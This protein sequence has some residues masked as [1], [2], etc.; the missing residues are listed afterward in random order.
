[1]KKNTVSYQNALK[2]IITDLKTISESTR[3]S[4]YD[5]S[6]MDYMGPGTEEVLGFDQDKDKELKTH[7]SIVDILADKYAQEMDSDARYIKEEGEEPT[8]E[9]NL[10]IETGSEPDEIDKILDD[11]E[12][13]ITGDE[14]GASDG[15]YITNESVEDEIVSRLLNEMEEIDN[16]IKQDKEEESPQAGTDA[17]DKDGDALEK[18]LD[19]RQDGVEADFAK[20]NHAK[21][22]E[23]LNHAD[24]EPLDIQE[25][26]NLI[27]EDLEMLDEYSLLEDLLFEDET[28]EHEKSETKEEEKKEDGAEDDGKKDDKSSEELDV[29]KNIEEGR[30]LGPIHIR[31]EDELLKEAYKV[32]REELEKD[33]SNMKPKKEEEEK[34]EVEEKDEPKE[35]KEDKDEDVTDKDVKEKLEKTEPEPVKEEQE[36]PEQNEIE[37]GGTPDKV[38]KTKQDL[39]DELLEMIMNEDIDDIDVASKEAD[40]EKDIKKDKDEKD[41]KDGDEEIE[42][43]ECNEDFNF[44][45]EFDFLNENEDLLEEILNSI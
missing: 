44:D 22:E 2:G 11:L 41:E 12:D 23:A 10:E 24:D 32:F 27:K 18:E 26:I 5:V 4:E 34:E 16:E 17:F 28:E 25:A 33:L 39:E 45:E 35:K 36:E 6:K 9:S 19:G 30:G 1:M 31:K 7:R 42:V 29:D 38:D 43:Q 14:S 20:S 21:E 15:A 13:Y 8:E 37:T 3:V 40:G